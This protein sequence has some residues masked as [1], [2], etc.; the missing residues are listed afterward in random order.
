MPREIACLLYA[1]D[2]YQLAS[3]IR[4]LLDAGVF[5]LLDRYTPANLAYQTAE[6]QGEKRGEFIKW[7]EG[8]E[9]RLPKPGLVVF[10]D[11]P[12]EESLKLME[13]R[14]PKNPS[15]K[16][17]KDVH[18]ADTAYLKKVRENYLRLAVEKNW[19][20]VNCLN[21]SGLKTIQEINNEIYSLLKTKK[22]I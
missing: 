9:S 17:K 21:S 19:V 10:L 13:S 20:V 15:L 2:R 5:V 3:K 7:L 22:F 4:L 12:V 6:M 18:E 14:Q 16:T 11:L 8:M 1:L